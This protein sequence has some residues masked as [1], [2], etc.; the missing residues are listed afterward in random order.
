MPLGLIVI[1]FIVLTAK[2]YYWFKLYV[3]TPNKTALNSSA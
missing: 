1:G 2:V 3:N